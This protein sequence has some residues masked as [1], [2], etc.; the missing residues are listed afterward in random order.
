[1]AGGAP[2]RVWGR[3]TSALLAALVA[4]PEPLPARELAYYAGLDSSRK[5][6]PLLR[7]WVLRGVVVVSKPRP[8]LAY[9]GVREELRRAVR[10]GLELY[11]RMRPLEL[12]LRRL[13]RLA[14]ARLLRRLRPVERE[15]LAL[16]LELAL[17]SGSRYLRVRGPPA[18]ALARLADT[19]RR[20]LARLGLDPAG[21]ARELAALPDALAELEE[22]HLVYTHYD[23]RAGALVVALD[24]G[25]LEQLGVT[26]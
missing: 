8:G 10:R 4:S 23:K 26:G 15:L 14:E 16:L 17:G 11:A 5:V 24:R 1:M 9:Y 3:Y 20:R 12:G 6:Y 7:Y 2:V 21:V 19:L 18:D 13:E 22:H 25:V